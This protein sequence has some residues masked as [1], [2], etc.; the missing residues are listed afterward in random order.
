MNR[1]NFIKNTSLTGLALPTAAAASFSI[2]KPFKENFDL[3][4]ITIPELQ[5]K[6]GSG[7]LTSR[8]ISETY[9]KRIKEIDKK[10]PELN[11]IIELNPDALS[12]ADQMDAE[13]KAG[14]SRGPMHGI[15]VLVKD[16]QTPATR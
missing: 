13:R 6:M 16:N 12:I 5:Q 1:R 15:P 7:E 4:E 9:L 3:N 8:S 10:G 2:N 14:K 11:S